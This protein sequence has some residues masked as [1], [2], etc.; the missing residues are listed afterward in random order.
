LNGDPKMGRLFHPP[1]FELIHVLIYYQ[2][3]SYILHDSVIM[4]TYCAD[5]VS[6]SPDM[7]S[8][9]EKKV[10]TL[11]AKGV[12]K[13]ARAVERLKDKLESDTK[14]VKRVIH[15]SQERL[16]GIHVPSKVY[17]LHE[18]HV[19][20]IRKGKRA[21]PNEYATKV[22]ISIDRHGY[23]VDH[24]E[25]ASTPQHS[26]LLEEACERCWEPLIAAQE[27][28]ALTEDSMLNNAPQLLIQL[29]LRKWLFP[30]KG[31][32]LIL[33]KRALGL[34]GCKGKEQR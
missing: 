27:S 5:T 12:N 29:R 21:T 1:Q 20:F 15:Q 11:Y 18:R 33:I 9:A 6:I 23:V 31:K 2:L 13:A 28:F 7:L 32:S 4:Q 16:R 3:Q 30:P 8:R 22:L 34:K 10:R 26:E 25:Y 17:S 14:L 19:A 24:Q